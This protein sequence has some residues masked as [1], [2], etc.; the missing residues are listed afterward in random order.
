MVIRGKKNKRNESKLEKKKKV[1]LSLFSDA[2]M[3]C[4][5]NS[6]DATRKLLE[7]INEFGKV[8]G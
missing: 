3:L 6:Q 4:K 5:V 2:K 1:K 8:A 7:S